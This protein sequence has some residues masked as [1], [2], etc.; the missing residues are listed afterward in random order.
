MRVNGSSE[1][2]CSHASHWLTFCLQES[3]LSR[4]AK[5]FIAAL[6]LYISYRVYEIFNGP[7]NESPSKDHSPE[8][9]PS[10]SVPTSDQ[11]SVSPTSASQT[12]APP[13]ITQPSAP[14]S[15]PPARISS[16]DQISQIPAIVNIP[17]KTLWGRALPAIHGGVTAQ[18]FIQNG[19]GLL[20]VIQ[21]N[22]EMAQ[23]NKVSQAEVAYHLRFIVEAARTPGSG[24]VYY[25]PK[26]KTSDRSKEPHEMPRFIVAFFKKKE[27]EPDIFRKKDQEMRENGSKEEV[28]IANVAVQMSYIRW[29]P[30]RE[31]YLCEFG[32]YSVGMDFETVMKVLFGRQKPP[33]ARTS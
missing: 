32:F 24:V 14:I 28:V 4:I 1:N 22:W 6:A 7:T 26:T 12:A 20:E 11:P 2:L 17:L 23:K 9:V 13:R 8:N 19:E 25:D 21:K 3:L 27:I 33:Q 15:L 29:T 5:V 16:R 10:T 31:K 30:L 18:G